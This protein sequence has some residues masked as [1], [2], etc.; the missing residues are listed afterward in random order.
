MST[1]RTAA[2]GALCASLALAAPAGAA[3]VRGTV[4]HRSSSSHTFDLVRSGGGLVA[5]ASTTVPRVGRTVRVTATTLADG[6]L[7]A[8]KVKVTGRAHRVRVSG[9]VSFA[10]RSHHRF[11]IAGEGASLAAKSSSVPA[12]GDDVTASGTLDHHGDMR[13]GHV[14]HHGEDHNGFRVEGTISAIDTTARTLRVTPE[15]D[16]DAPGASVTISVPAD[17]D[18]STF[19]VGQQVELAVMLQAD[20][21]LVLVSM[22]GSHDGMQIEGTVTAIDTTA[23][24]ITVTPAADG[25]GDDVATTTPATPVTISVPDG[26]DLSTFTVGQTV[27]LEVATQADG[28]LLLVAVDDQHGDGPGQHGSGDGGQSGPGGGDPGEGSGPGDGGHH[29]G[30]GDDPPESGSDS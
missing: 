8:T 3:T 1:K 6:T 26:F 14:R 23:R 20:G 27:D 5:V 7:R 13:A 30:S 10:S 2:L 21:T 16:D 25:S 22:T 12:V 29:G 9:T 18:I 4:V 11:V 17:V 15:A 28:T 19:T 24:T